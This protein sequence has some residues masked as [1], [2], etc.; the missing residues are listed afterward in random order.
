MSRV[1]LV[2]PVDEKKFN[3][4]SAERYGEI[5]VVQYENENRP[6]IFSDDYNGW[7]WDRLRTFGRYDYLLLCGNMLQNCKASAI[8]ARRWKNFKAL[9]Y[10]APKTRYDVVLLGDT[11]ESLT[12]R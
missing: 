8:I 1:Y 11:R 6:P 5:V 10:N 12:I 3:L 9:A 4:S 7:L 2:E